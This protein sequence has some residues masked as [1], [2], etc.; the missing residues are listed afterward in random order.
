VSNGY[1]VYRVA[2]RRRTPR[3]GY[4]FSATLGGEK[5]EVGGVCGGVEVSTNVP[6]TDLF[7]NPDEEMMFHAAL[8]VPLGDKIDMAVH[9]LQTF[10]NRAL[11]LSDSGINA[12]FS[13]GKDSQALSELLSMSGCKHVL[14]YANTTVDPPQLYAFIRE[15]YP[16]AIWHNAGVGSLPLY[17]VNK[18]MGLPTRTGKWCCEIFKEQV[19]N[20]FVKAVGVR[21]QE[22]PRR[23]GLWRTVHTFNGDIVL[24]PILYWTEDDVWEFLKLRN[25]PHCCLYDP[26]FNFKR[27]GCLGCPSSGDKRKIEFALFPRYEALWKRGAK[28]AWETFHNKLKKD[29]QFYFMHKFKCW[30]DY[31][32]WWMEEKNVNDTDQPDC[33]AWLW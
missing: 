9:L 12:G 14:N 23:K 4:A 15:H 22:S 2:K 28:A 16:Q 3:R 25:L 1:G 20:G 27:I 29:G 30:E 13:G 17:A 19:G 7:G 33:Q 26:P 21:A 6:M 10:E 5:R 11:E 8:A 24:A 32:S 18:S 31:W